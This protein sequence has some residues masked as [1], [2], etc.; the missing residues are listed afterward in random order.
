[1]TKTKKMTSGETR[2]ERESRNARV[3]PP[4]HRGDIVSRLGMKFQRPGSRL[5][6]RA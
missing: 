3:V 6:S 1:M 5:V 2:A 4:V